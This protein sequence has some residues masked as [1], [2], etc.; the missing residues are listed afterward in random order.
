MLEFFESLNIHELICLSIVHIAAISFF[1][2]IA[3]ISLYRQRIHTL[4]VVNNLIALCSFVLCLLCNYS[5]K[6]VDQRT[7]FTHIS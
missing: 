3:V 1:L 5:V 7:F 4:T 6:H 2:S